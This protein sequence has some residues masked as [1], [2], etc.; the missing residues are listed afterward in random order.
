MGLESIPQAIT[1]GQGLQLTPTAELA[2][3]V[4][5]P[6]DF[7]V[8]L[9]IVPNTLRREAVLTVLY[10]DGVDPYG[11]IPTFATG[12]LLIP[13]R[14]HTTRDGIF[15]KGDRMPGGAELFNSQIVRV[16]GTGLNF[17]LEGS[18]Q[19]FETTLRLGDPDAG[20]RVPAGSIV[21]EEI[22]RTFEDGVHTVFLRAPENYVWADPHSGCGIVRHQRPAQG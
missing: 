13:L 8:T 2:L 10:Y 7:T 11:T 15:L 3:N 17:R 9:T 21:V 20:A 22:S 12:G 4:T 19:V 1:S 6:D 18:P 14:I 5:D 16:P